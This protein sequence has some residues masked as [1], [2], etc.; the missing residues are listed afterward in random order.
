MSTGVEMR[1]LREPLTRERT[2]ATTVTE[3]AAGGSMAQ[4]VGGL[5]AV[6]LAIIGLAT[7]GTSI[8]FY[9]MSIATIVLGAAVLV[10]AAACIGRHAKLLTSAHRGGALSA[11]GS[12]GGMTVEFVG[13]AAAIVLGILAI[14][15][16]YPV[17][18]A[19]VAALT[20]GACLLMGAGAMARP[21]PVSE[22]SFDTSELIAREAAAGAASTQALVGLGAIILGILALVGLVPLTL[23]LVAW[24]CLGAAVTFT[25]AAISGKMISVLQR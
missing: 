12:S 24:L 16:I 21:N 11:A 2:Q 3:A 7:E 13:G 6:V 22:M 5:A 4:A 14:L 15:N 18:L 9:M 1:D 20:L 25:G 8:P 19:A 23:T 17:T 10:G